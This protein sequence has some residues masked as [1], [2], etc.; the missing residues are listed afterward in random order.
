MLGGKGRDYGVTKKVYA[1]NVCTCRRGKTFDLSVD[2][3]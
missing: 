1:K 3:F 2:S